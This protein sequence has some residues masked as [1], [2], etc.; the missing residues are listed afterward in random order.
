AVWP[1]TFVV[2]ANLKVNMATLRRALGDGRAGNRYIVNDSGLG[3]RFVATI[4]SV[5]KPSSELSRPEAAAPPTNLPAQLTRL[6]ARRETVSTI[7]RHFPSERLL[8][9]VGTAGVGKTAVAL[10]AAAELLPA[11]ADGVWLIDLAPIS[12]PLLAPMAAAAN[13]RIEIRSADPLRELLA[14]IRDKRMLLVLDNCEH[15]IDAAAELAAGILRAARDV[16]ILATSRE[17]LRVEGER[18]LKLSPLASPP[19]S[20]RL[21]T[22][23]ALRFPA[24]ELFV[25]RATA[26]VDDFELTDAEA[27]TVGHI[28]RK[29]DGIPLAIEL[30][31]ARV[32]VFSVRGLASRLDDCL[33]LLVDGRRAALPRNQTMAA[34]LEWSHGLLNDDEQTVFRRLS[35]FAGSFALEG[36]LAVA[37]SAQ[38]ATLDVAEAVASLVAKS[39]V[40]ADFGD[41]EVRFRLLE[42]T[43][44]F[45][46]GKLAESADEPATRRRH[47]EHYRNLLLSM[48]SRS[49]KDDSASA[50]ILEL[51]NLRAALNWALGPEGDAAIG[52]AL[53][54]A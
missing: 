51:D 2:D 25:E 47:A 3:Y 48:A 36:A 46:L 42:T 39:L 8:T 12:D 37:A 29:L 21:S 10:E 14:A 26:A 15:L 9:V 19:A 20:M 44:A 33:R 40:A 54:S 6:V 16:A 18:V 32:G 45:A 23:E 5:D 50:H 41:S 31:A 28:C 38:T 17:P 1:D 30:A 27:T 7:M 49:T 52:I 22:A 13:L 53:A 24:V 43:R 35:V 34:A 4:V 11:F